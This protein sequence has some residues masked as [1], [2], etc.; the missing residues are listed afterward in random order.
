MSTLKL[1]SVNVQNLKRKTQNKEII[2]LS[3]ISI[4]PPHQ[5]LN[6]FDLI[7]T[8]IQKMKRLVPKKEAQYSE[9]RKQKQNLKKIQKNAKTKLIRKSLIGNNTEWDKKTN[10]SREEWDLWIKTCQTKITS[11]LCPKLETQN[12]K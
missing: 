1:T 3:L 4:W 5:N 11:C 10:Q 7:P 8:L 12:T 6:R 2:R 9:K